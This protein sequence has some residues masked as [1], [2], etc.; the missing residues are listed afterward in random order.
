M[1]LRKPSSGSLEESPRK[2]KN[3][4]TCNR[5]DK[6]RPYSDYRLRSDGTPLDK[7]CKECINPEKYALA[8]E[9]LKLWEAGKWK[10]YTCKEIKSTSEFPK[11]PKNNPS[12]CK[13]CK[14]AWSRE[15]REKNNEALRAKDSEN[16]KRRKKLDPEKVRDGDRRRALKYMFGLTLED[17]DE[18]FQDQNG[19]CGICQKPSAGRNLAVDH[20]RRCCSGSR[21]CGNCIRGLLCGSC[22]PKLGFYE[23]F[24][25]EV[26]AW[27]DKRITKNVRNVEV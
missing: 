6:E 10:C 5:C 23:I 9:R 11:H 26:D 13:E 18:M 27:R 24:E 22:N 25:N 8:Q 2:F 20:D 7:V 12:R 21:S 16:R 3:Y 15:Y 1:T 19:L 4:E 14:R 17:Y